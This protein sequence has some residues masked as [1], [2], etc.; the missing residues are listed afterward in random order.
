MTGHLPSGTVTFLL[1]DLEGSTRM[2]EQDPDAMRAAMVRHDEILERTITSNRGFVFSRMGDGMAA[3][4]SSAGEAVA[5]AVA[6]KQALAEENW[7]TAGALKARIGLHTAEAVIVDDGGYASLPI[8]RCARLMAAAHGGQIVLSGATEPLVR[9]QLPEGFELTDLGEHRLRDLGRRLQVFQLSSASRPEEFPALRSLDAFPGNLPAQASSFIGRQ[10]EVSRVASA[11]EE[12]RVVTVTGVGGVGKTRMAIQLAAEL[13][14]RYR[15]GAW[16]VEL[17]PVRDPD[18][19]VGAVA[20][21]FRLTNRSGQAIEQSLLEMLASKQLLVVLD[22]CEHLIGAVARL[23]TRIERECP[24]VVVLATSREGLAIDGEQLIALPPLEAGTP[25]D[26]L[27]RLRATD[28]VRLFVER[29]RH[30]KADFALTDTNARAVVEICQRLDGVPLAIELAAARVIALGPTDLARRLDRRF[31][32]LAGGRRGAVERHATLR[33]AIDWSYELLSSAEQRLLARL[34]VFSGGC[35]LDAIEEVC[36]GDPVEREAIMDLVTGLVARSLVVAEDSGSGTRFRLFETIRQYG[37]E[38]LAEWGETDALATKHARF[39]ADLSARAAEHYYGPEQLAWARQ[40]NHER[41][42][43]RAALASAIDASNAALAVQLVANH[44]HHQGYGGTGEVFEIE[45]PASRVLELPNA[46]KEA[47]YPRVLMAAAWHAYI[48]GNYDSADGLSREAVE[49][50]S[51]QP[52][53]LRR[54]RVEMDAC[55]L[56]AMASLAAGAYTDAVSAYSRSAELATADGYP[57]LAAIGLAVGVNTALL[58]GADSREVTAQAEEALALARQ[59]GM[60]GAIVMS[61]NSLALTLVDLDPARARAL[62]EESIECI[63]APDEANPSG[64]LTACLVAGRLA[65]WDLTVALATRSLH[66]ERWIPTPMQVATCLAL[67]ARALAEGQPEL[68]G[69]LQG[70]AYATFGR[71]ASEAGSNRQSGTAP[72]GPNAN[73]VLT[74]LRE[75]GNIAAVALGD[76]RLHELRTIGKA[77]TMDEA[78]AHALTNIDRTDR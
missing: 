42:N 49:A 17:A 9:D 58:G 8:N 54:P 6:I 30:V 73:F 59:S 69:V 27:D 64:V 11:L 1:T 38:K 3:A 29:A 33:A 68:A 46:R 43:I 39:Y 31:Q 16:L 51:P 2:W 24:G 10:A 74:A 20:A 53:T 41:D 56:R 60:H 23:V 5:G 61:L 66:L 7:P 14:P 28:A 13:L 65:D 40:I 12:S 72:V 50:D 35:T 57:G 19:V 63:G 18:A 70:A 75:V 34:A 77:M 26:D 22:N 71:A 25:S 48:R 55:N 21:A 36:G 4:F 52:D 67:Y 32:V 62:L 45:V 78:I 44:P 76:E 15:E 37:E 47:G